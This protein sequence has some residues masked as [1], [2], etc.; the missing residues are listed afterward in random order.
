[1]DLL[2]EP[3]EKVLKNPGSPADALTNAWFYGEPEP[4]SDWT[5]EDELERWIEASEHNPLV[6]EGCRRLLDCTGSEKFPMPPAL[7]L[8][9]IN[10]ARERLKKP[11]Y[12]HGQHATDHTWRNAR[13]AQAVEML[14]GS[15]CTLN[16][17]CEE[18]AGLI[19]DP[20]EDL[21]VD[22]VLKIYKDTQRD[23]KRFFANLFFPSF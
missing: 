14:R 9:G 2:R 16:E 17:A 3:M 11:K 15:G 20:K 10:I 22:L 1:M 21:K 13:I 4:G 8:W 23:P 7:A 5:R 18:V 6:W 19:T 12:K